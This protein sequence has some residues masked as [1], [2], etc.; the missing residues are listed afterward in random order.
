M[1]RNTFLIVDTRAG[2]MVDAYSSRIEA[3]RDLGNAFT[4]AGTRSLVV[5]ELTMTDLAKI[6]AKQSEGIQPIES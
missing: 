2:R 1:S 4:K 5:V 3:A 6:T